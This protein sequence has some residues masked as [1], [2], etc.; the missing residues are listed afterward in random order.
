[1][2]RALQAGVKKMLLPAVDSE[3]VDRLRKMV[4]DYPD[5]C[6][7][8]A[9][10]HPT[11]VTSDYERELAL[12]ESQLKQADLNY[13][14]VGEIGLDLYWDTTFIREQEEVLRRQLQFA[15]EYQLPVVL[16][17]RSA[18]KE[19]LPNTLSTTLDA[20]ELFFDIWNGLQSEFQKAKNKKQNILGVMH[21]FSGTVDQA[22]RAIDLG[23]RIGVGGVV[24][25]K[26]SLLQQVVSA[27]PIESIILETDA[28][29]LAPVPHRGKRNESAYVADIARKVAEIKELSYDTVAEKTTQSAIQLF[30][31]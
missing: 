4:E 10:L 20:Y 7:P 16:H 24:T 27:I 19:N 21:C 17:L 26:N 25:Y 28:P 9:G 11:S 23:F 29:Y 30:F 1:V 15:T 6:F 8:M 14:A 3:S 2:Q 5:I 22:V 18:K 13:V 31:S 12:V